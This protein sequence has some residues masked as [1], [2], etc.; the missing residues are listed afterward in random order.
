MELQEDVDEQDPIA[1]VDES[2]KLLCA[3]WAVAADCWEGFDD[4]EEERAHELYAEGDDVFVDA[5]FWVVLDAGRVG[6]P[7]D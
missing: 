5:S 3:F 4:I 6:L 2:W 1:R 7:V